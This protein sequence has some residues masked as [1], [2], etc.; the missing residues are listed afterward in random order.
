M[1]NR[2]FF[3]TTTTKLSI[4]LEPKKIQKVFVRIKNLDK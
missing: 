1:E 4:Y 2:E 3:F